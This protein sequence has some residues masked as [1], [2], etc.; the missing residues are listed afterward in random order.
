[1]FE[2]N[3]QRFMALNGGPQFSFSPAVSLIMHC[4]DQAEVDHYWATLGHG[5]TESRC[6]WL[7]DKFGFSW[8]VVPKAL[9][10]LLGSDDRAAANR[11]MVAMMDMQK[12]DIARLEAAFAGRQS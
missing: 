3:G 2:A 1:M 6:G 8:Q 5:G 7:R 9:A 10:R 4:D 12:L 11:A